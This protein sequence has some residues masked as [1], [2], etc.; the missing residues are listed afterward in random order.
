MGLAYA[1]SPIG[2]SHM[3]GDPAYFELFAVPESMDPHVWEGKAKVTKAFQDLSAIIDSAG[4]CIFFAVRNLAAKDLGVAPTGILEYLNAATGIEYTLEEL[5]AAGERI[6]NLERL[7]L[8]EAGFTKKDD[9]LPDRLTRTP[10]PTGPAK[11]MVCH[12]DEMLEE[13]YEAQGW[14]QDGIPGD[15]VIER[16]GLKNIFTG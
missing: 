12:L 8:A 14:S 9:S 3:R 16:L 6:I 4:L 1:T 13:Y 11:G 7:F 10:A 5:M 15:P 2:G